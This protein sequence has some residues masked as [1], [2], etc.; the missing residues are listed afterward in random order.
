M[1]Y[2]EQ[3]HTTMAEL[4]RPARFYFVRHGESAGNVARKMQGHL[5]SPLTDRGRR[6][7]ARMGQWFRSGEVTV[8]HL[9]TSP[10][11]RARETAEILAHHGEMPS[12]EILEAAKELDTGIFTNLSMDEI[13]E[14]YPREYA[15]FIVKSWES[16]PEAESMDALAARGVAVWRAVVDA[17]NGGSD[18]ST[19]TVVTVT[20]GGVLQ[21]ILKVGLGAAQSGQLS[22]MPLVLASNAAVFSFTARPVR[23][24]TDDGEVNWYYGQWS[25]MN[26]VPDGDGT[27]AVTAP[28]QF[29]TR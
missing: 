5:D 26:H 13:A 8:D 2:A 1:N 14:R 27:G 29:H 11:Q 6:Q 17:V 18:H 15:E 24:R 4:K 7:A 19:R 25:L 22:W 16:V 12:P 9:L 21:W 23:S 3:F 28:E 20:H 10:L